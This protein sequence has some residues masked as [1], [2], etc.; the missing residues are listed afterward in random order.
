MD[1]FMFWIWF[2]LITFAIFIISQDRRWNENSQLRYE[3]NNEIF[4]KGYKKPTT[5]KQ[6]TN[7]LCNSCNTKFTIGSK[8]CMQC[9]TKL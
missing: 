1:W 7:Q 2:G 6:Q 4:T 5:I 8:W 9:G 3:K